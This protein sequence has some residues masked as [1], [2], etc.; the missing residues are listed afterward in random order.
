LYGDDDE[1]GVRILQDFK[2]KGF[3]R[4]GVDSF[5]MAEKK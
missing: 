3:R 2:R 1:S 5:I 4:G